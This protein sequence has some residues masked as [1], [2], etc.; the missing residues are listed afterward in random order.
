MALSIYDII[1]QASHGHIDGLTKLSFKHIRRCGSEEELEEA[2]SQ[3][4]AAGGYGNL[5]D[6]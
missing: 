3:M 4:E 6:D 1:M 5:P 2:V